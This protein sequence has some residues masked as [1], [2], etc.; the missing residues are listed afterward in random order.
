M[1]AI[2]RDEYGSPDRL[3]LRE[4]DIPEP[5][6]G[7]VRVRVKAAGTNAGDH[8][9]LRG[10]PWLVRPMAGGMFRPK[11]RILGG[12]VAGTVDTVGS[13]VT[14]WKVG[15]EVVGE[16][17]SHGYGG[18]ADFVCAAA[19]AFVA[20]P[21]AVPPEVAAVVPTAGIT[22]LQAVRD[23]G[24]ARAGQRVLV[25]G[26]SGGVGTFAV[27]IARDLGTEV[28]GVCSGRNA[29]MVR[30]IGAHHVVD[31]TAHDV[32]TLGEKYDLIVDVAA[33]RSFRDYRPIVA[34]G[35]RY[36]LVGGK[37][38][39]L[40]QAMLLGPL[41]SALDDRTFGF[42]IVQPNPEHLRTLL[43]M[44]A[45]RRLNPV[46]DRHYPLEKVPDAIRYMETRRARGKV[47]IDL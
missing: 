22:A 20:R 39:W 13:A 30:S 44:I 21:D 1:R 33:F 18:F 29:E 9:L 4:V 8:H 7:E 5:A 26:A 12:N 23:E 15:E 37:P 34:P 36:V 31:Y 41:V 32:T 19:G 46:I 2:V 27:Q 45:E 43:D 14:A 28:T 35:G 3:S 47:V 17:S 16:L 25:V 11:I 6:P 24:G 42:F 38:K 40:Y 10:S